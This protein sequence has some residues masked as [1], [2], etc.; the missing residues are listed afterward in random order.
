MCR[1]EGCPNPKSPKAGKGLCSSHY[2]QLQRG[3]ELAPLQ[4]RRNVCEPWLEAHKAH[5]G[6][7][8]LIWPF[9]RLQSDG[10]GAVK[11]H[12]KQT[13]AARV[14]CMLAHGEPPTP[15]HE[16][17][18][19]CGKGHEGCV[20]PKHLRWATRVENKA[21]MIAHGTRP[22]GEKQGSS[23]L[24]TADVL[25]IR[26]ATGLSQSTLAK[27]F[28]VRQSTIHKILSRQRWRHI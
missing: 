18:H 12:G 4:Y 27:R 11:Y 22:W 20:N 5:D 19:S 25:A 14:M 10:R 23:K 26:A 13:I 17:A 6:D 3:L 28:G 2:N 16:A 9:Q 8:C 15:E 24:K 7:E 21:D 1:F